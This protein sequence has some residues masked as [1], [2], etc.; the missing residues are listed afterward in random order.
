MRGRVH[1]NVLFQSS[2][3]SSEDIDAVIGGMETRVSDVMNESL[4]QPFSPDEVKHAIFQMYP[5]KSSGP[6]GMSPIFFQKYWH[7]V[8]PEAT[9]EALHCVGRVLKLFEKASGLTVNL[10]KSSVAFS[11]NISNAHGLA[12]A[13]IL[14][15]QSWRCKNLSQAGKVVLLK[16]VVQSIPVYAMSCFQVPLSTCGEL[17]GLMADFLWHNKG[18]RRIHW[19]AWN[20]L[21]AKKV[22]GGL[23]FRKMSAFNQVMLAKQLWRLISKPNN[24]L[25]RI[26]KQRYFPTSDIFEARVAAG[27]SFT[28]RSILATRN[29][30]AS[31][32]RWKIGSGQQ[33]RV[34]LDR[35]IP[36]PIS[37]RV[38]TAPN[39]LGLQAT[40]SELI[41]ERGD[42]DV[43]LIRKIFRIEDVDV[44]LN[45]PVAVGSSDLLRWHFKNHGSYSVRSGYNL[46][47]KGAVSGILQDCSGSSSSKPARWNFVWT[48]VV[49]PKGRQHWGSCPWCGLESE[50]ILHTLLQRHFARLVWALS[51]I[52]WGCVNSDHKDPEVWF[53]GLHHNLDA[54]T[55]GRALLICWSIW[56][57]RNKLIFENF[58]VS[59]DE[60]LRR[61]LSLEESFLKGRLGA[62]EMDKSRQANHG[63]LLFG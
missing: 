60:I 36:R 50:D 25:S 42:W 17:K 57:A 63:N 9:S 45:I 56:G 39:T 54:T 10:E 1:G 8:G 33:I 32:S 43:T 40:V 16:T 12:L 27:C 61:V 35:W 26:W 23:G 55:F 14:G 5:Y 30:I 3:P 59:A 19:L 51:N 34:W 28:W 38:I 24:L 7:I 11:R 41:D 58:T 31:G 37:F 4:T 62:K 21:C 20:K 2:H 48:A 6:D 18:G 52:P 47:L 29:L 44:I 15:V 46:M 13:N 53:C 49:P 22:E